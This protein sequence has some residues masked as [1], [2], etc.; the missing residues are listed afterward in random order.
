M[1]P[2]GGFEKLLGRTSPND[3]ILSISHGSAIILDGTYNWSIISRA[4][5]T[6]MQRCKLTELT[7]NFT[8]LPSSKG[9][10][11]STPRLKSQKEVIIGPF[12]ARKIS[13]T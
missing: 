6:S 8:P 1:R 3:E 2:L 10:H 5:F 4:A 11:C 12:S 9:I 13:Q 7:I